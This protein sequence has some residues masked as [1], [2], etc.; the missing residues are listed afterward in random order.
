MTVVGA[1]VGGGGRAAQTNLSGARVQD[2]P[3]ALDTFLES[4]ERRAFRL[5][6][7]ATRNDDD[8]LDV[9]K[10]AMMRLVSHYADAGAQE[11]PMLFQRIL[12]N[13]VRDWQRRQIVRSRWQ[14]AGLLRGGL[15]SV[16]MCLSLAL[17]AASPAQA[18]SFAFDQL[19]S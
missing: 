1:V 15:Q 3:Q 19:T 17:V 18:Q 4:V 10:E 5:A 11:W 12:Q 6:R 8:A 13:R 14:F 7:Y 2:K 9:V 16:A